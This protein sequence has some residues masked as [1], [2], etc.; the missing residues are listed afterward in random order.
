MAETYKSSACKLGSQIILYRY[1]DYASIQRIHNTGY[2][3]QYHMERDDTY[4]KQAQGWYIIAFRSLRLVS[5]VIY[6]V[7]FEVTFE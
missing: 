7:K 5:I 2:T 3:I 1:N 4:T 6:L